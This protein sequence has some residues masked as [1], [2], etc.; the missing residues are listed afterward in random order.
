MICAPLAKYQGL[1][2]RVCRPRALS[3]EDARRVV[4]YAARPVGKL[5]DMDNIVDRTRCFLPAGNVP[6]RFRGQ[7]LHFGAGKPTEVICSA[8]VSA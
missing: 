8:L 4:E 3:H 1:L 7:A 5:Y 2:V 6:A